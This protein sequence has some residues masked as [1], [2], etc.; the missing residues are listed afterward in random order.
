MAEVDLQR[1]H[2]SSKQE[3][4]KATLGL[5]IDDTGGTDHTEAFA[6][7]IRTL[8]VKNGAANNVIFNVEGGFRRNDETID[9]YTL[10][11]RTD[12]G[13]TYDVAAITQAGSVDAIYEISPTPVTDYIRVSVGTGNANGTDFYLHVEI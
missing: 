11:T 7:L 1:K 4:G 13:D 2:R 10:A 9:W 5:A 8:E 6:Y 3:G 12:A